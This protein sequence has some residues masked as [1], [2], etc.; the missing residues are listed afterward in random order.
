MDACHSAANASR[1][2]DKAKTGVEK[3]REG[4][5]AAGDGRRMTGQRAA[6][7]FGRYVQAARRD[8]ETCFFC[9]L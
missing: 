3:P 4:E 1:S 7:G 6:V 9:P 8:E 2:C 5:G